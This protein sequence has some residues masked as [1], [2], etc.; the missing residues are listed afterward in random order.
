MMLLL[1]AAC[2]SDPSPAPADITVSAPTPLLRRL[3]VE[4]YQNVLKDLFGPAYVMPSDIEELTASDGL[5]ELGASIS[6]LSSSGVEQLE[7]NAFDMAEQALDE[8]HRMFTVPCNPTATVDEV[9]AAQ[10]VA[11]FGRR[12]WRRPLTTAEVGTYTGLA[13]RAAAT[14]GD[15]YQGLQY[16]IVGI[17]QS[18]NFAYRIELGEED[19]DNPGQRRLTSVELASR[20]SFFFWNTLPDEELLA[21]G[22]RG[23]LLE[24]ANL[25]M[26]ARRL[27][28]DERAKVG[29]RAF[30]TDLL[31]LYNLDVLSKDPT[32]FTHYS[33]DLGAAAKEETLLGLEHI[34][35]T[36]DGDY[37]TF[38]TTQT[39]F[40]NPKLAAIY[41]VPAPSLD[42][43]GMTTLASD[44]GRRGFLGQASFLALNAH[45]VSTSATKRGKYIREVLLC[46]TIPP[47]PAG[48]NTAIPESTAET[49]TL[50]D[51]VEQH[52]LDPSCA[53]CHNLMDPIGLGLENFD[54]VGSWRVTENGAVIDPSGDLDGEPYSN[55]WELGQLI[56]SHEDT[57]PCLAKDLYKY[58]VGH[59][60][61]TGEEAQVEA[62]AQAFAASNYSVKS[63]LLAI[64]TSEGFRTVGEIE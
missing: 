27:L 46:Q 59:S 37:R 49:P 1:L 12:A 44:G 11:S 33:A 40:I 23:E 43:F 48:L 61:D 54:G 25:E 22:E 62:L 18:P 53:A 15:F 45:A 19:P 31:Q 58:A 28:A 9:C 36:T 57:G 10:F 8:T 47:P 21:A 32:I 34:I 24:P 50:R 20:L 60:I 39:A 14:L 17:M 4:Q 52:L 6:S 2:T 29:V 51:R 63:L 38:F 35:F 41:N 13:N 26:Q 30:F 56:Y 7:E 64:A 16:A 42:G 3:T 55:A 5:V